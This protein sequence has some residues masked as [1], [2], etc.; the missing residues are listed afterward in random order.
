[1]AATAETYLTAEEFAR[2]PSP[3]EGGT[4]E[5]V[6]GR[7]VC[8]APPGPEHGEKASDIDFALKSFV[9]QHRLGAVRVE[10][11]YWLAHD[12]DTQRGPDVS[13]V[14]AERLETERL[15][16]GAVDQPPDLAVE[17]ISPNDTDREVAAKV[18][19]YL[20]AG[21]RRVWVVRLEIKTVTVYRPGGD[22]HVYHV[23]ETL[24]S[25]DA[26]F[27]VDGFALPLAELFGR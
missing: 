17:V 7:V 21:V 5:L 15:Y 24:T 9:R 26:G 18:E 8:V 14:S 6:R 16:H 27:A 19:E 12:P 11:G 1:M 10:S 23:G 3:P 2:M 13:Y 20:V 25:D 4:L 22:A